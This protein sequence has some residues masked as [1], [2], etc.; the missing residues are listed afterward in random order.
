VK[1]LEQRIQNKQ[2][3]RQMA[4]HAGLHGGHFFPFSVLII[5]VR[6][7]DGMAKV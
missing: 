2:D 7:R 4:S 1:L 3:N 6:S 5:Q